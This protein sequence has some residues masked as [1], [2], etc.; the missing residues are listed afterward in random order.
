MGPRAAAGQTLN[1]PAIYRPWPRSVL[2]LKL[3]LSDEY[4]QVAVL[5]MRSGRGVIN[6][7][8]HIFAVATLASL[9][10]G[11]CAP[12]RVGELKQRRSRAQPVQWRPGRAVGCSRGSVLLGSIGGAVPRGKAG[13]TCESVVDHDLAV[14][15]TSGQMNKTPGGRAGP[16]GCGPSTAGWILGSN[17][18]G[19]L[20]C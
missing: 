7:C 5:M 14:A 9:G 6:T 16:A 8:A 11:G 3:A 13:V 19:F 15:G 12:P 10:A 17:H 4:F 2:S 18:L 1:L 20:I